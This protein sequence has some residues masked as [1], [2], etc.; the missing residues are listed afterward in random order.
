[1]DIQG[2]LDKVG[3]VVANEA[4]ERLGCR[5]TAFEAGRT[6]GDSV[7]V[8]L[9]L[10]HKDISTSAQFKLPLHLTQRLTGLHHLQ[11]ELELGVQLNR[12]IAP[13]ALGR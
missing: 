1:M 13:F 9:G 2:T 3:L 11:G 5:A 7:W 10:A 4:A 6:D 12:Y 8:T